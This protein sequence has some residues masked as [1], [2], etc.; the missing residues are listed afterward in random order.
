MIETEFK[1]ELAKAQRSYFSA[2]ITD[3]EIFQLNM[4]ILSTMIHTLLGGYSS[5]ML[6]KLLGYYLTNSND[7]KEVKQE[8]ADE[9]KKYIEL[10]DMINSNK[11]ELYVLDEA[12]TGFEGE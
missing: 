3:D 9:T 7:K 12:L 1:K 10:S 6:V 2:N 5:A 11:T 4:E 8:I